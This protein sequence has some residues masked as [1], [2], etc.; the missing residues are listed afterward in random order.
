MTVIVEV[1]KYAARRYNVNLSRIVGR[2]RNPVHITT[3]APDRSLAVE[4]GPSRFSPAC[5]RV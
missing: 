2:V 5:G 3:G 4:F 1:N